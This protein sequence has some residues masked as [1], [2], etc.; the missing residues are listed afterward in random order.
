MDVVVSLSQDSI[1]SAIRDSLVDP[2]HATSLSLSPVLPK[3]TT[4]RVCLLAL[5]DTLTTMIVD[6]NENGFMDICR[7]KYI[8]CFK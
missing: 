4:A 6:A 7:K 3:L 5:F 8:F 1:S 2:N